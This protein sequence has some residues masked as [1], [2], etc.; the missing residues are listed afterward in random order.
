MRWFEDLPATISSAVED[1]RLDAIQ[2]LNPNIEWEDIWGRT[3]D[4][5]RTGKEPGGRTRPALTVPALSNRTLRFRREAGTLA[6]DRKDELGNEIALEFLQ[7]LMGED[8]IRGNNTFAFGRDLTTEEVDRLDDYLR[9]EKLPERAQARRRTAAARAAA[10]RQNQPGQNS[11]QNVQQAP[12]AYHVGQQSAQQAQPPRASTQ[13]APQ[14]TTYGS[15]QSAS[16]RPQAQVNQNS[17][18]PST[19]RYAASR[20][21][22]GPSASVPS[23][24]A[25]YPANPNYGAPNQNGKRGHDVTNEYRQSAPAAKR[26]RADDP[27]SIIQAR[28]GSVR[29]SGYLH[30]HQPRP[31]NPLHRSNVLSP[32]SRVRGAQTQASNNNAASVPTNSAHFG[33]HA[34]NASRKRAHEESDDEEE[35]GN[36]MQHKK[37]RVHQASISQVSGTRQTRRPAQRPYRPSEA[38]ARSVGEQIGT[39]A[40]PGPLSNSQ[41]DMRTR[42]EPR[43][44]GRVRHAATVVSDN[45]A[46]AP[47]NGYMDIT[48]SVPVGSEIVVKPRNQTYSLVGT[49]IPGQNVDWKVVERM[50]PTASNNAEDL[51]PSVGAEQGDPD[52]QG[53]QTTARSSNRMINE[54]LPRTINPA[55]STRNVRPAVE[56]CGPPLGLPEDFVE[57]GFEPDGYEDA[58]QYQNESQTEN[59]DLSATTMGASYH[60]AQ[61]ADET[62]VED[63]DLSA[64]TLGA[65]IDASPPAENYRY[66]PADTQ[67]IG[68]TNE[69]D[70]E[71]S[72]SSPLFGGNLAGT[73]EID[74]FTQLGIPHYTTEEMDDLLNEA[75]NIAN[76]SFMND[77]N[78]AAENN[79][80]ETFALPQADTL[81]LPAS[82]FYDSTYEQ[83][84]TE[85]PNEFGLSLFDESFPLVDDILDPTNDVDFLQDERLDGIQGQGASSPPDQGEFP[86]LTGAQRVTPETTVLS[87]PVETPEVPVGP[88]PPQGSGP[89]IDWDAI[90][91]KG[92]TKELLAEQP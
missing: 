29:G 34:E 67:V 55:R 71:A 26:P 83:T 64:S 24:Q 68:E 77:P 38:L 37:P 51:G 62:Q 79:P 86:G 20:C 56:D 48:I 45:V 58:V 76:A 36:Q 44:N 19:S 4:N 59:F 7:D 16:H 25:V 87:D 6:W 85:Y 40:P 23:S 47:N 74:Y 70:F 8:C 41:S 53:H 17:Q 80:T 1:F 15:A 78:A 39:R 54:R 92:Y 31:I 84:P 9:A 72:A 89:P 52:W 63:F 49:A 61:Y 32:Y 50:A 57:E 11:R 65:P 81:G 69:P 30:L 28:P 90:F 82:G 73:P 14:P 2:K 18:G 27:G 10:P 21:R 5:F 66:Y 3:P 46:P 33:G 75:D 22:Q 60:T 88:H 13:Q 43:A 35:E 42:N 12:P 91:G